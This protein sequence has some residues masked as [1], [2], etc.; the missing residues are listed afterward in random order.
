[1]TTATGTANAGQVI[2]WTMA[3]PFIIRVL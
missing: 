2:G 3:L 1:L